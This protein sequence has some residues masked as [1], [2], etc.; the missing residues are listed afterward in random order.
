MTSWQRLAASLTLVLVCTPHAG[1]ASPAA[2]LAAPAPEYRVKGAYLFNLIR[3]VDWPLQ[4]APGGW[5]LPVCVLGD[6]P[7]A[8]ALESMAGAPVRGRRLVVRR[9][10]SVDE[11]DACPVLFISEQAGTDLEAIVGAVSGAVLTVSE[12]DTDDR[13]GS[14]IN[15]VVELDRIGF[16]VNVQAAARARL[17]LSARLLSAARAVDGRKR[18][19]D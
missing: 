15:F 13:V 3:L 2:S 6:S 19:Q 7:I 11:A 8:D 14:V 4:G 10:A 1:S 17:S 16:D 12:V 18:R 9:I 5:A